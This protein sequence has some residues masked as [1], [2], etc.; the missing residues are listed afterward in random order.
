[1]Y[2]YTGWA[3]SAATV[4]LFTVSVMMLAAMK[5]PEAELEM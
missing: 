3:V 1:M 5:A 4:P 2:F